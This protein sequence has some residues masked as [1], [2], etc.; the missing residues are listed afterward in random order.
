MLLLICALAGVGSLAT[1]G[2][3]VTCMVNA[4]PARLRGTGLGFGQGFGRLGAIAGP[5]YLAAAT[6]LV[7]SPRA[8]F[9]AF[10]VLALLG[11][12]AIAALPRRRAAPAPSTPVSALTA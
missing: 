11:G 4:Y 8:G 6:A 3:V 9:Y 10:A 7:A 12:L 5:P 2:L 1:Q